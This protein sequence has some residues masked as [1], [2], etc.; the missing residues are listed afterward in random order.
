MTRNAR[1]TWFTLLAALVFVG[2]TLMAV[3]HID[4]CGVDRATQ[5]PLVNVDVPTRY[6]F[7]AAPILVA[8]SLGYFHRYLIRLWD[9]LGAAPARLK[10]IRLGDAI[11][12]WLVTDATLHLRRRMRGDNATTPRT[13]EGCAMVLNCLLA[14]GFRLIILYLLCQQSMPAR[15]FWMTAIAAACLALSIITGASSIAMLARRMCRPPEGDLPALWTGVGQ[16]A[17]LLIGGATLLWCS[18]QQ[19]EG[20]IDGLARLDLAGEAIVERPA[21]WLSCADASAEFR[22]DW[23]RREGIENCADLGDREAAFAADFAR[24]RAAAL[25]D[26]GRPDWHKPV[27]A[28]TGL[29]FRNAF[30]DGSVSV[31]EEFRAQ[32]GAPCQWVTGVIADDADFYGRWRGSIEARPDDVIF[33]RWAEVATEA[34]RNAPAIPPPPGCAWKTGPMPG[35]E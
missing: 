13:L 31:T 1:T 22:A 30:L 29:D 9:A 12:P 14:W 21:G 32:M 26:L 11:A 34:F 24:R 8:A 10:G 18:Y 20:Q 23:C 7:V 28:E 35:A 25:A 27:P 33:E 5:L 6:F 3:A 2:I 16:I 4:F 15:T 19:T 17:G